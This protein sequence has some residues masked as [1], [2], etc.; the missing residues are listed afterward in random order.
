MSINIVLIEAGKSYEDIKT[1][2]NPTIIISVNI[3]FVISK[4]GNKR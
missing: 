2:I 3:I 4:I 1:D